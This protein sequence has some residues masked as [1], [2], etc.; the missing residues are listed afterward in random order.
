[1]KQILNHFTE[2][3][4]E[5][6]DLPNTEFKGPYTVTATVATAKTIATAQLWYKYGDEDWA[7]LTMTNN[8]SGVYSADLP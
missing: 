3:Q 1:L 2:I 8:G 6:I 7:F 4:T 5:V